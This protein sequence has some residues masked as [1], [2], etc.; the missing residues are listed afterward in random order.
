MKKMHQQINEWYAALS[1]IYVIAD[2]KDNI[3]QNLRHLIIDG[4]VS[5]AIIRNSLLLSK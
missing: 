2:I 4:N 5:N 1:D 3:V